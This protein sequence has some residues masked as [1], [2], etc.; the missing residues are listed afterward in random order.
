MSFGLIDFKSYPYG[1]ASFTNKK[2]VT[3]YGYG[4][5]LNALLDA[6]S[7]SEGATSIK[8][9]ASDGVTYTMSLSDIRAD[10]G[11]IVSIES[12]GSLRSYIPSR[13]T[14]GQAHLRGLIEIQVS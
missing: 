2:K 1:Y 5:L 9:I 4:P 6:A 8:L 7:P 10:T 13:P 12:D 3:S 14:D 11:A